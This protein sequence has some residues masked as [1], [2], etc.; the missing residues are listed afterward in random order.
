MKRGSSI[1][2]N[3]LEGGVDVLPILGLVDDC[4]RAV[5]LQ[6]G[7]RYQPPAEHH[8]RSPVEQG[9]LG[10]ISP[11]CLEERSEEAEDDCGADEALPLLDLGVLVPDALA[12]EGEEMVAIRTT[13]EIERP[14]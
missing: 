10:E 12:L 3:G 9:I 11:R 1:T 13:S 7:H 4:L 5:V 8:M 14:A 2:Y 6:I